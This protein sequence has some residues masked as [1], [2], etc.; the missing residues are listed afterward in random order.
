[1]DC[2][3]RTTDCGLFVKH[4]LQSQKKVVGKVLYNLTVVK[5]RAENAIFQNDQ[6]HKNREIERGRSVEIVSSIP[7]P[8]I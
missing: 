8:P 7:C 6:T 1:M 2:R 3:L 5:L 4:G